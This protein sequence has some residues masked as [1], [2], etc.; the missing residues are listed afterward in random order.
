MKRMRLTWLAI[1]L[2]VLGLVMTGCFSLEEKQSLNR[3]I[4]KIVT[5]ASNTVVISEVYYDTPGTDSKEE[6]IELYNMSSS[7]ID[8]SNWTLTDNYSTYTLP[9]GTVIQSQSTL[10]IAKDSNG[11][12][13]LFGFNPDISGLSLALS[14][15]GDQ[16]ILKDSSGN[17][18]DYV[19]W[20]GYVTGWNIYAKTG[21]S[22]E[23]NPADVDT[24]TESD[25][26][27]N[28]APTPGT[29]N[30]GSS[31]SSGSNT[32]GDTGGSSGGSTGTGENP[33]PGVLKVHFIDVG[34]GDA[35]LIQAPTGE[36]MMIDAGSWESEIENKVISYL[37]NLGLDH[38]D[39]T[40]ATHPHSDHIGSLDAVINNWP[41]YKAYDSGLV[42]TSQSYDDYMNAIETNNVP[43]YLARRGDSFYLSPD[44][45]VEILSPTDAIVNNPQYTNDVSV[46]LRLTYGNTSFIFTG[47]AG[48]NIETEI[49]AEGYNVD[50]DVLK[51]GHHGSYTATAPEF[52]DAVTPTVGAV[53]MCGENNPYGHPH[54]E[55][56]DT[57]NS[58][59]ITI[60]RTDLDGA[61]NG[62]IVMTSDGNT[63]TVTTY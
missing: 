12:N 46:V 52:V 28:V 2:M 45:Y 44:V 25:W 13:S 5:L 11:F 49:M 38:I 16:L 59:N 23:R 9:G 47:D 14:N 24:D 57:L 18:V 7:A 17:A 60:Y 19:A 10:I 42:Y 34:Q 54:Q 40:V 4:E 41:V 53:I 35:I 31:G 62:D 8:L 15:S 61:L 22:I 58:R 30:G 32:G 55:T 20:E 39:V 21:N 48:Q 36:A 51:V 27:S 56:L 50:A 1:M 33:A 29:V 3:D 37:T 26:V 43:L 63:I 6:Y